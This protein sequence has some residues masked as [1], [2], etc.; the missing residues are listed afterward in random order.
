M[1]ISC[2]CSG[3]TFSLMDVGKPAPPNPTEPLA[4]TASTKLSR[5]LTWGGARSSHTRCSPSVSMTMAVSYR[6]LELSTW[7]SFFTLP[8]TPEW[9]GADTGPPAWA[10][11][12]P[13]FTS[14]PTLTTG[15]AGAPMFID[16]GTVIT[17]GTGIRTG[18][19]SAVFFL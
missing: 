8:D 16:M 10:I 18:A 14:S 6:P 19:A 5:S 4:R 1:M 15:W 3:L 13:T 17:A 12:W 11:N 2:T 7:S 9:M